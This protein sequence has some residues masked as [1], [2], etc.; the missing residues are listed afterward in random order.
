MGLDKDFKRGLE[1]LFRR[2]IAWLLSAV[3]QKQ[4]G[5]APRFNKKTVRPKLNILTEIAQS[6]LV[7]KR[8][9]KEF[10]RSTSDPRRWHPKSGRKGIGVDSKKASFK[11][12][13]DK[14]MDSSNSVY[15]F[16][17][18]KK[19][20]YVGRTLRG[21]G[22]PT[23]HF[24]KYWF[25]SVTRVAIY[26]VQKSSDVPRAECLAIHLFKPRRNKVKSAKVKYT[27][28]CSVCSGVKGIRQELRDLFR[29]R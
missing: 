15:V 5:P 29:L 25:R 7:Y 9:R 17:S 11:R 18:K 12:W 23:S 22:R 13:Y 1:K 24:E 4:P 27:K 28:K 26:T 3:G 2:R 21:K 20:E 8:G 10:R 16:W 6:I 19:C 14:T